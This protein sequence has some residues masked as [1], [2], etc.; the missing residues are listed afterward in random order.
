MGDLSLK[1]ERQRMGLF[2]R[3]HERHRTNRIGWLRAAVLGP[4]M[5][6]FRLQVLFLALPQLM[7]RTTAF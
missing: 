2:M 6:S 1:P 3:H 7:V 5:A 4:T